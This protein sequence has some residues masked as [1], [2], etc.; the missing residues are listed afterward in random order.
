MNLDRPFVGSSYLL[1]FVA[2][3]IVLTTSCS[4][5]LGETAT[6]PADEPTV[7]E[8]PET[9]GA[10]EAEEFAEEIEW[11]NALGY[12][13]A[14]EEAPDDSNVTVHKPELAEAGWNF[15]VSG[16]G[17]YAYLMDMDG[18]IHHEWHHSFEDL[19]A[20]RGSTGNGD[21]SLE[22]LHWRRAYLYPN[23]DIL[24][25]H[26]HAGMIKLSRDSELIWDYDAPTHHDMEVMD[27]GR[28]F[29]LTFEED[30]APGLKPKSSVMSDYIV[31]LDANG[32][33]L[34]KVSIL[35][36]VLNADLPE[37]M[38]VLPVQKD[39][40]HT[41]TIKILDGS[42]EDRAPAFKKGNV[43]VS[44][45]MEHTLAV[46]DLDAKKVVWTLTGDWRFQHEPTPLANGNVLLF[47]NFGPAMRDVE[48][49]AKRGAFQNLWYRYI[50]SPDEPPNAASAVYE[51]DP[52]DGSIVW[53]YYGPEDDP[54]RS[55]T[56]GA[57]YR[58]DN[59]NTLI[60]ETQF[61]RALEVTPD[62]E[63]VWEYVS[64]HR[65]MT[66]IARLFDLQRIAP[67]YIE[68]WAPYPDETE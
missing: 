39:L 15:Y 48:A 2:G 67:E 31:E 16:H 25:I 45:L 57:A 44:F 66:N 13:G 51:L 49:P 24:A 19:R 42:L 28:I 9:E 32:N 18:A 38:A 41:N 33:E 26:T 1:A 6:A 3:A 54:L 36:C 58:L 8:A 34:R 40:F 14:S 60:V 29:T 56:C 47:D 63:V 46:I 37:L 7:A 50:F 27:D 43:L 30:E 23:G 21:P 65:I 22:S 55:E 59:G 20:A 12:V 62:K 64:P 61:G 10:D 52:R 17:P 68:D 11:L 35:E 4:E 5:N 53:A